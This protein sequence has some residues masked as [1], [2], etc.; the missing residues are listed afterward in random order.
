MFFAKRRIRRAG[1]R[2]TATVVS[3]EY[4]SEHTTNELRDFDY[5]LSV[6]PAEGEAFDARVRDKFW[7]VD[8]KPREGDEDVPVRFDPA[9]REVVFDFAGDPRYDVDAMNAR[10]AE[11]RAE[12]RAM[13]GSR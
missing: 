13:R 8:L 3:C 10:S 1:Q 7:I 9:S 4:R 11:M 5:V 6:Q 2:A 12:T